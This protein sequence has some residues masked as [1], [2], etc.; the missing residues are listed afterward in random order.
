ME[1]NFK[2]FSCAFVKAYIEIKFIGFLFHQRGRKV[3]DSLYGR[4]YMVGPHFFYY[5]QVKQ[6]QRL[7]ITGVQFV[8]LLFIG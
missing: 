1:N 3:K 5:D 7:I 2:K 6:D 4:N 8:S